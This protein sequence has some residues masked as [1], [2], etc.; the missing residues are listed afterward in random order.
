LAVIHHFGGNRAQNIE[1]TAVGRRLRHHGLKPSD[2]IG[3]R[4]S[5]R[6]TKRD[7]AAA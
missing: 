4:L 5:G 7:V 6:F 2:L 1:V 3:L